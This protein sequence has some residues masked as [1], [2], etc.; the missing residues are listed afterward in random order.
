[1]VELY[2]VLAFFLVVVLCIFL[3]LK[4]AARSAASDQRASEM[5]AGLRKVSR[6][7]EAL[8]SPL[9]FGKDLISS[10]RSKSRWV[11]NK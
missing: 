3:V 9:K 6:F 8:S 1:M 7:N 4:F 2:L 5:E 10:L 11:S